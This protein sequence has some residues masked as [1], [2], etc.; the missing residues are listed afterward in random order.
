MNEVIL[1][2]K[3]I[4]KDFP[5]VRALNGVNFTLHKGETLALVGENGA[6]KST[7]MNVLSGV[8]TDY[9]GDILLRGSKVKF[10]GTRDAERA[11]IAIIHQELNLLY[12][13]SV[14]ENIFLGE[15]PVTGGIFT[16]YGKMRERTK[17][18]LSS[19]DIE[20]DPSIEVKHLSV[21]KQQ[22]IEIARA[23]SKNSEILI[24]DEPTSALSDKEAS[25][26]FKI[27]EKL[28][29]SGV[30][31]VYISHRMNEIFSLPDN[32][33]V[34]RDGASV[35]TWE[36]GELTLE[37]LIKH[38]VGREIS[39]IYPEIKNVPGKTILEVKDF[40][41]DHPLL[42]GERI[43]RDINFDLREGE[44]LGIAGLMGSGRTELVEGLFGAFPAETSGT[45]IL[46]SEEVRIKVPR[47]A[48]DNGFSLA[49]EDRKALGLILPHSVKHNI[50]LG[51][52]NELKN[53]FI[54]D[55]RNEDSLVN[56]YIRSLRIKTP[57]CDFTVGN[58]SGGNQQKII[59]AKCLASHP[60]ILILDEP[61]RGI[62]IGSKSEI[63][64]LIKELSEKGISII[65]VS[66]ELPEILKLSTRI[67]VMHKGKLKKILD[68][69]EATQDKIMH[70]ATG[71]E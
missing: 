61:T 42:V 54:I 26:L 31:I 32:I 53:L 62:D 58:L 19:L 47:D 22:M 41:V 37:T 60:K 33:C 8:Y 34:L 39:Q 36:R 35:G 9:S 5:G 48:L 49:T 70:F 46:D 13:L 14:M 59:L 23:I 68:A 21:G 50:T 69:K 63:Y 24:F 44:I 11:G 64:C 52:L 65:M 18:L 20:I 1:E 2:M 55:E 57:D 38:M 28:K 51:I 7:L 16:D 6:G 29:A 12:E 4:I 10:S 3:G 45:V 25:A 66:S 27:M 30:S 17:N 56:D 15:E 67:L 40:Y 71:G 43:V